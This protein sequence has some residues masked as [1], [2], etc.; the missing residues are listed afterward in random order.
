VYKNKTYSRTNLKSRGDK[1]RGRDC[2]KGGLSLSSLVIATFP[3]VTSN[4]VLN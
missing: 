1:R 2:L 4:C 3:L